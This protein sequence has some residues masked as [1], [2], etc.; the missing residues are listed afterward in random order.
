MYQLSKSLTYFSHLQ[1]Y[2]SPAS[3]AANRVWFHFN[4]RDQK[5]TVAARGI[6]ATVV[7]KDIGTING[8]VHVIDRILG[9]PYQ[10]IY[11]RLSTDPNLSHFWSLLVQ[12]HLDKIFT[13]NNATTYTDHYDPYTQSRGPKFT[14]VVPSNAAWEKAQ[15]NFHK[16]YNTLLDGQFPQYVSCFL[17]KISK[18]H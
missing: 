7:E 11:Q 8:V 5:M 12:T 9:V 17:R 15:M 1:T 4:P 3:L 2:S 18:P 6:N 14:L 13:Q 16:A 10:S